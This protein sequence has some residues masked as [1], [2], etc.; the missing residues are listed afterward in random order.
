MAA[1][2]P[3]GLFNRGFAAFIDT[4]TGVTSTQFTSKG[5]PKV[6]KQHLEL[7]RKAGSVIET[8]AADAGEYPL[9]GIQGNYW[10]VR[11]ERA[12]PSLKIQGIGNISGA[13]LKD[14]TGQ[15][16]NVGNVYF[17]DGTRTVRNLK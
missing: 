16:R 9:N 10:Y 14:S 8:I 4:V 7:R 13:K 3:Y 6:H 11:G 17:K 2:Q 15:I 12:F 5:G 1:N